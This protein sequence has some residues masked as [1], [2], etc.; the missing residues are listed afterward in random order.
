MRKN[1]H[2][3]RS[4][5]DKLA[6]IFFSAAFR[7]KKKPAKTNQGRPHLITCVKVGLG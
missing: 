5:F 3:L 6:G 1:M 4:V 2:N 7:N